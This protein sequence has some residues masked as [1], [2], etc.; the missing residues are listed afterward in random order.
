MSLETREGDQSILSILSQ[1]SLQ[2]TETVLHLNLSTQSLDLNIWP[3][4]VV[5]TNTNTNTFHTAK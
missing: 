2:H 1:W 3:A 4:V 5:N